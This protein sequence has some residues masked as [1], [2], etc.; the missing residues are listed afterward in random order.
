MTT[1]ERYFVKDK[2]THTEIKNP[3]FVWAEREDFALK[4]LEEFGCGG[5]NAWVNCPSSRQGTQ[6]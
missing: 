5:P 3:Y 1:F 6:P 4:L 2:S